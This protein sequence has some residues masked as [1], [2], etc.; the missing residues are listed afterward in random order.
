MALFKGLLSS[1][2]EHEEVKTTYAKASAVRPLAEKMITKA[3]KGT[4]HARR[5][6][7]SDLQN[8]DLIKKLFSDIALRFKS[9]K[10]GFTKITRIGNRRGDN[11]VMV[12]LTLTKKATTADAGKVT[13][14]TKA[15]KTSKKKV[16]APKVSPKIAKPT[17]ATQVTSTKSAI[18]RKSGD[19]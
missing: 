13:K 8:N 14:T 7:H 1:L 5:Q 10:G 15:E 16:S 3:I 12:K 19:R 17:R 18:G 11:A 6:V 9:Q 4:V 2:M